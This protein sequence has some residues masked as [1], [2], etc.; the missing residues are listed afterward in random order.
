MH[1]GLITCRPDASLGQVAAMLT[2][3][4][5]HA[6]VVADRDGRPLGVISDFDLLAA[7]WLST[8]AASLKAMRAMTA[9]ELM[10]APIDTIE[11]DAPAGHA[12]ERMRAEGISRLLVT[13]AGKPAGVISISDLV[14]SM[15]QAAEV[16]RGTVADVMSRAIL[17][18]RDA[19]PLPDVARGMTDARYRSVLVVDAQGKSLGVISGLDLLAYCGEAG[20]ADAKAAEVMHPA[21]TVSPAA[22]LREAADKMIENHHHRLVVVDPDQPESMP[23]GII[24]SYDIVN[25]MARPGSVW[26]P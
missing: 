23:L 22:T 15:T 5:I 24:S 7:E 2:Q 9:G 26:R 20:C 10:T 16:G 11:A 17:V 6:L 14:A 19:T 1:P 4:R 18:C 3:H 12:A 25:E 8:D 13:D 21:L